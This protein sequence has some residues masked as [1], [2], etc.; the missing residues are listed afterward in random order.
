MRINGYNIEFNFEPS[1]STYKEIYSVG[2]KKEL[3]HS[4]EAFKKEFGVF[5]SKQDS[6][7]AG[8]HEFDIKKVSFDD[9]R[10]YIELNLSEKF[11]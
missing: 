3:L 4:V 7:W 2:L 10:K 1:N 11:K 5:P 6:L 8:N 9:G